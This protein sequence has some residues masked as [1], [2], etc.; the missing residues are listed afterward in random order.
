MSKNLKIIYAHDTL[1]GWCYGFIPA[2]RHFAEQQPE[3]GIEVVPG[4]LM[5]GSPARPY[6]E[7]SAYI[8]G[9]EVRLKEVTGHKPSD[10][11]HAMITSD[12]NIVAASER[13]GHAVMQMNELAPDRTVEFAHLL[14][15]AHFG[16]GK[17]VNDPK[18]YDDLCAEHGFP[19]LDT[20]AITK[21]TLADPLVAKSFERCRKLGP[22]GYP[23]IFVAN[24][25]GTVIGTIPSTYDPAAFLAE[26]IQV[27][28]EQAVSKRSI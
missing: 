19:T 1:C 18:T 6:S 10:A 2:L 16:L 27:Q 24:E 9:A 7:M 4:G 3:V 26:F 23:T 25:D 15:E 8:K 13:P 20:D 14:Q 17:D 12:D 28:D 5:T 22:S 21:A 11:F